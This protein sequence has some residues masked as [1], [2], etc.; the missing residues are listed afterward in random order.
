MI[1]NITVSKFLDMVV[2][3]WKT[4]TRP[5]GF[6]QSPVISPQARMRGGISDSRIGDQSNRNT[7]EYTTE[8]KYF[9]LNSLNSSSLTRKA[10]L[11]KKSYSKCN[12]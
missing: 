2:R 3:G 4:G 8:F 11:L 12:R 9:F 10:M 7:R 1:N 6:Q 5:P